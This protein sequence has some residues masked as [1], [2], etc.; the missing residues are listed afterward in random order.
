MSSSFGTSMMSKARILN[1]YSMESPKSVH[2]FGVVRSFLRYFGDSES[3]T[4]LLKT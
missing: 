4:K 2:Y 1:K 3:S